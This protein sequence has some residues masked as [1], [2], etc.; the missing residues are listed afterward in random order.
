MNQAI[1][2][3]VVLLLLATSCHPGVVLD[4]MNNTGERLVIVTLNASSQE[5]HHGAVK[6]GQ[7]ARTGIPVR[8]RID[9]SGG[10]WNYD[11]PAIP[12]SYLWRKGKTVSVIR[13]QVEP[14]GAIYVLPSGIKGPLGSFPAQPPGYPVRPSYS[15]AQNADQ[16]DS[17]L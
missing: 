10:T 14:D 2:A 12:E 11:P 17:S 13:L 7:T 15:N 4:W 9:H 5:T 3:F 1:C 6:E 16:E 8:L